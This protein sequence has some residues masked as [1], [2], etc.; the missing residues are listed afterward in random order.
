MQV[1][2][3]S[4]TWIYTIVGVVIFHFIVGIAYLIYKIY[5]GK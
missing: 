2:M 3:I 4:N 5:R 1:L